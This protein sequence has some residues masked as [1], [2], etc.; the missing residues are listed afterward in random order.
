[1]KTPATLALSLAAT[2]AV[3][4]PGHGQPGWFHQHTDAL[5]EA[6]MIALACLV[7]VLVVKLMWKALAR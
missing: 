7:A 5:A 2:T 6:A 4:H 1:L 3:A